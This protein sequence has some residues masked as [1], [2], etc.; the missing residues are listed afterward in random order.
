MKRWT[1]IL[2]TGLVL[3]VSAFGQ[4]DTRV[5]YTD[6]KLVR[7]TLATPQDVDTMLSI[8][9][10]HWSEGVGVGQFVFRVAPDRMGELEASGLP[11]TVI[12]DNVQALI[13]AERP[14]IAPRGWFDDY[15]TYADISAYVDTLVALR[16]DLVTRLT[17]GPS[18][19]ARTI[20]GIKITSSVNGPDK[21]AVLFN[22]C[23]HARE[24]ISPA[25]VMYIADRLIRDYDTDPHVQ[26]LVDDVIFYIVPIVNPDG[27]TY[28]WTNERLWRKN[29]RNNGDGSFGVDLNRNWGEG[30]GLDS[31]SSGFPGSE[32][33]RGTAPFS[34][35]E[36]QVVRDF[37]LAH[38]EIG[39]HID[40]H[41]YSQL[42][43]YPYDW[44]AAFP[45]EPDLTTFL[46]LSAGMADAIFNTHGKVYVDEAGWELYLASGTMP[47][48]MY[49]N[50]DILG[51]TIELRPT[52]SPGF[53][54]PA[55]EIIPTGEESLAAIQVLADYIAVQLEFA[56]PDGLPSIAPTDGSGTVTVEI[57]ENSAALE[58]NS[59]TIYTRIGTSGLFAASPL[60]DLGGDLYEGSLPAAACGEVIQYYIEVQSSLGSTLTSPDDAPARVYEANVFEIDIA[61]A[62]DME[63]D[64]G[65]TVGAPTDTAFAG[66]WSRMDPEQTESTSGAVAQPEDDHTPGGTFCWVTD[67][68]AGSSIGANDV[69]GGATT[70]LTP[71]LDLSATNDPVI[72]YF[73][74][75]SN[76]T[77]NAPNQD[78]FVVDVS[79]DGVNWATVET[80]GPGGEETSGGWVY[81]EFHPA[82]FVS[83]TNQVQVRF[84]ASDVGSGSIVEA[85]VDDFQVTDAGC[86]E[87]P[88]PG[89]LDGDADT[90]LDDLTLLLQVF[91]QAPGGDIDGDGDTD[92]DD[93][94]L[95]LQ[96]F[97]S[98]C[99]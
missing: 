53:I 85:L 17:L 64:Q 74:W 49:I 8:S 37:V 38:P 52:G 84:V 34:E 45:P 32:T 28:T 13:D 60:A 18:L 16:P 4:A 76:D 91:G 98:A 95:L 1:S 77:G 12:H 33:Y 62:D 94:T 23:Q 56:F 43:L 90:D 87:T 15:K 39:A 88:C 30:W 51:W 22:G 42:V 71:V 2:V 20:F 72:S 6:H 9:P 96:N 69:D 73:R 79:D 70:L 82:D 65:W 27:Y 58:P 46:N 7:V 47:D 75:F 93:L 80:V 78:V 5:D 24:W 67:G 83:L 99:A 89:D 50:Q 29:R 40:F 48:W 54:L 57:R 61:F 63:A 97:G 3:A 35:P 11:F 10:D 36:T 68:N 55:S 14:A 41:S 81:H 92:L 19:E 31:G 44:E 66:I 21:P 25:T 26:Q 86:A 59:P